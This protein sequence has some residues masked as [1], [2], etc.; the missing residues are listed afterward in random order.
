MFSLDSV[1]TEPDSWT[2]RWC[3]ACG[4]TLPTP[5]VGIGSQNARRV[6]G[7]VV[8]FARVTLAHRNMC[9]GKRKEEDEEG[10]EEPLIP[11]VHE[12]THGLEQQLR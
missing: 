9:F 5:R 11:S 1:R 10:N 4:N 12:V 2:S 3:C 8:G 7:S 6:G